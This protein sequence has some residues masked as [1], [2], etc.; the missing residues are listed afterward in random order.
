MVVY[1]AVEC[2]SD[3]RQGKAYV[4]INFQGKKLKKQWLIKIKRRN[5]QS[6]QHASTAPPLCNK[7][8][9]TLGLCDVQICTN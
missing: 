1:V 9:L 2:Q 8:N 4:F 3:G 5:I 6:M 7:D